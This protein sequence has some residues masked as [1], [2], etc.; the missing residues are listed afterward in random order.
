MDL[1]VF[2]STVASA[3]DGNT[4]LETLGG[5]VA[6]MGRASFGN[7]ANIFNATPLDRTKSYCLTLS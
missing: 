4:T 3:R 2:A 5:N 1:G 6:L 7:L